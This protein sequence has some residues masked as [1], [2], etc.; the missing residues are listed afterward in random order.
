MPT[1]DQNDG[2]DKEAFE[3]TSTVERK[4]MRSKNRMFLGVCSGIAEF[5][6]IDATLVRLIVVFFSLAGIGSGIVVYLIA[7]IIIPKAPGHN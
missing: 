5:F 1:Q 2:Q 7:A 6:R 4:L 3:E